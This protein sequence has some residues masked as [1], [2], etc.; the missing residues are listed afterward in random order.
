MTSYLFALVDGGGT[1][2]PELGAVRRLVERGHRVEVLAEDSMIDDVS[3][4]GAVFRSWT[5]AVNR[6]DRAPENDPFRDWE[7]RSPLQLFSRMLDGVLA[8][9]APDYAAD[10]TA[11][12]REY[13]PDVAVCSF[14]A[15]GAMVAAEAAGIPCYV[16]MANIYGLPAPGMPP[17]GLGAQP[18]TGPL[19]R[20]RDRVVTALVRRQW[21]KGLARINQLRKSYGLNPIDDFWDQV[22]HADKVLVLTSAAFDFPAQLP[23]SVRYVG[24]VLDDPAWAAHEPWTP[25]PGDSPMVLVAMSS[26][27]QDHLDVLQRCIEGLASLPVRGLVTTGQAISPTDLRA[28][29][30]VTVVASAPHS[31]VL[32]HAAVVL[33]H[34][35]HGTVVRALAAGV[36][37]VVMPQG[38]DQP[39]NAVRVVTR[40][41]GI[42]ISK[43]AA[44]DEIA[45]AV[46]GV[47]DDGAFRTAADRLGEAIRSDAAA[48]SLVAELEAAP[49]IRPVTP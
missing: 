14:F 5:R 27:F 21:N 41:A 29:P 20:I 37:M 48:G 32:D 18:A 19:T 45:K 30:R 40:G 11:V 33:T 36:P 16:L 35:G 46:Q 13:R 15:I 22:R 7:I 9:P 49:T 42:A 17:L 31:E 24:P 3:A 47:L 26:T 44:P 34:G 39:D 28:A 1:V 10:L 2:P 43:S 8:G 25:P 23:P 12:L 38:R 4:A 6:P